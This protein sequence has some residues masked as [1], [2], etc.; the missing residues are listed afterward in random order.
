MNNTRNRNNGS[1]E[2]VARELG[3]NLYRNGIN[4]KICQESLYNS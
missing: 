2:G 4:E 3:E 1:M